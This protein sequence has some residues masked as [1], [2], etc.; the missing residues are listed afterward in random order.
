[1]KLRVVVFLVLTAAAIAARQQRPYLNAAVEAAHWIESNAIKSD[2]GAT[3]PTIPPDKKTINTSLYS[4]TPGIV[5]FFLEAYRDT[6]DKRY[7][8]DA[9]GGADSLIASLSQEKQTGL[10]TG[11]AGIGFA[12]EE[13]YK[14]THD[15]KYRDATIACVQK[16]KDSAV[17][18]G[19]GVQWSDTNDIISGTAGTGLFLLYAARELNDHA[20]RDL[21]AGAG[22]RLIEVGHPDSGGLRWMIDS[23]YPRN[24]PNFS[25]GTAGITYFLTTLYADTKEKEFLDAAL[26]GAKYLI[27]IANTEGDQCL[28]FHADPDGK[29]RYYLGW[30]HGPAGTARTFYRL[31]Q[32]TGDNTWM[33]WTK[34]S[35]RGLLNSGIPE[36]RT[37]GFWN[38]VGWCCG[39]A[40]VAQFALEMYEITKDKNYLDFARRLTSDLLARGTREGD[41]MKWSHAE[42]RVK[43]GEL[44]AQ[45][46]LMQGAAGI[47]LWL[48][49]LDEFERDKKDWINL[50]DSP[51]GAN[52]H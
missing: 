12:L 33:D 27:S 45:T 26:L 20:A 49:H 5:L 34:K 10:Y 52:S 19:R 1:M 23:K 14:T 8:T 2:H 46:G 31:Y 29:N 15:S 16:I 21:A 4:G 37:D 39:S 36:K 11:L 44:T 43:P 38:N 7:L 51:F 6:G 42:N 3:W 13:T 32:V 22:K 9:R 35:M 41:D 50:P 18:A 48:L 40:S 25:H 17:K 24:M 28:I 47:G 30:C